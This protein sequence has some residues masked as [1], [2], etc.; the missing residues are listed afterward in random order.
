[1]VLLLQQAT[2]SAGL[3]FDLGQ[4]K[5]METWSKSLENHNMTI[6]M[7]SQWQVHYVNSHNL[8]WSGNRYI[9]CS[10]GLFILPDE[11]TIAHCGQDI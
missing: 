1:M 7:F 5:L 4:E 3:P 6:P 8:E 10:G 2:L 9:G 11:F